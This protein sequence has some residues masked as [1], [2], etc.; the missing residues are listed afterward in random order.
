MAPDIQ[1]LALRLKGLPLAEIRRQL[2]GLG[3]ALPLSARFELLHLLGVYHHPESVSGVGSTLRETA[4]LRAA[5]PAL[6]REERVRSLLDIPCGDFHWMQQVALDVEGVDYTGA[7]VVPAIVEANQKIH[8]G[9]R[10]RFVVLDATRDPL[11][12]VDLILCRDLLIHLSNDDVLA[13][14][15]SFAR[16]G[17]RLLLTSHFA[18]RTDNPD[19]ASGDFRPIHLCRAPF[20]LPAPLRVLPEDSEL[21][22]GAFSD[23]AMALWR[24]ADVAAA[25]G[26]WED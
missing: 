26:V 8:G 12:A 10:R 9:G 1:G 25:L 20:H 24:L 19:I 21:A 3:E 23:R 2:E 6:V 15:R 11:P 4:R 5:L 22:G 14:L 7:D 17:S 16:S 13:A 18:D